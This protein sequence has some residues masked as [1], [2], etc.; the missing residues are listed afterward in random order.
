M[1]NSRWTKD[2]STDVDFYDV[3][4]GY[5]LASNV[6]NVQDNIHRAAAG[7]SATRA[8]DVLYSHDG[9]HRLAHAQEGEK[10]LAGSPYTATPPPQSR[11]TEGCW[12]RG[13]A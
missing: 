11:S 4:V 2:L 13:R 6:V 8:F 1:V 10:R 5:D 3:E 7:A 12:P 9:L